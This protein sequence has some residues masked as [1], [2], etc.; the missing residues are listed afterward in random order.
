MTPAVAEAAFATV[1]LGLLLVAASRA[2]LD[3]ARDRCRLVGHQPPVPG[4]EDRE[5]IG[6]PPR[7]RW[8]YCRRCGRPV[9]V[10]GQAD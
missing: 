7:G 9:G 1:V 5:G 8:F 2:L 6:V 4:P 3:A 10:R